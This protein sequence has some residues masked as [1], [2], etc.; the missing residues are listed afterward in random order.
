M[1][2]AALPATELVD[3]GFAVHLAAVRALG[4]NTAML[5]LP[6]DQMEPAEGQFSR[7]VMEQHVGL[8]EK[9]RAADIAPV[10]VLWGGVAPQWFE[11]RGGWAHPKAAASFAAYAAHVAEKLAPQCACWVPLAEPEYWLARTYH[12]GKRPG[13]RNALTQ[14]ARAHNDAAA[15]LRA[16]RPDAQVGL[17]VRVFSAE[18]ADVD[19]PWDFG[20]AQRLESRLN[21][22]M[23]DRLRATG[24]QGAFDFA[25]ASWGGVVSAWFSPWQWRREWMLTMNEHR[26]CISLQAA[27]RDMARFDEAMSALL[28]YQTPLLIVGEGGC[29]QPSALDEQLRAVA[30]RRAEE[31]GERIVGFL[32]RGPVDKDGWEQNRSLLETMLAGVKSWPRDLD[33]GDKTGLTQSRQGAKTQ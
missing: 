27:H 16:A 26:A 30:A 33:E 7:T 23:A 21:H 14:M 31:G 15:A 24:G 4:H 18:P 11:T 3:D 22:R 9:L 20:A 5:V 2:G 8:F 13:Y 25:L 29:E 1:I 28:S 12:E 32:L 10:G 6:W 17:S 19:S